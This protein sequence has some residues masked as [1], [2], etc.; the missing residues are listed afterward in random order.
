[1]IA[2]AVT[3]LNE[4]TPILHFDQGWQY[5]M[6]V[7]QVILLIHGIRQSMSRKGNCLDNAAMESFFER[8]KTTCYEGKKFDTFEQ[9]EKTIHEY[10]HY[11]NH[12]RIQCKPKRTKP[13]GVQN[14][15]LDLTA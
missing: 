8:L 15:V 11:Y 5:Q 13:S 14:S 1:M 9:L 7:Y 6:R 4:E 12:E 3:R 10:I 2:Q